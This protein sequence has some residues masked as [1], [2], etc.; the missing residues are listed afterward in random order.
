M[1]TLV[2][3]RHGQSQWNL[4]NRFTGWV[5]VDLSKQGEAEAVAAGQTLRDAGIRPDVVHTSVQKRAIRT[6]ELAL[7]EMGSQPEVRRSWRLN[8]RHYGMLQ[9]LDKKETVQEHGEEQVKVWRRSYATPPP[10]MTDEQWQEQRAESVYADVP[11]ADLPRS[12]S[13]ADVVKRMMPYW[14]NDI[15]A[16]L[17]AGKLVLV[18]AHGNSLRALVK[19][20]QG[21]S[22]DE[23]LE[24]NIPTGVPLVYELDD[25]LRP[26]P[27][28]P[29]EERYLGD[30]EAVRAAAQAVAR[31]TGD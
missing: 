7:Q 23:I 28:K 21:Y 3:L 5:D 4:D 22:E 11:D 17:R 15:A 19:D 12:E 26:D 6:A 31:Q 18:V 30:P 14:E 13:L 10:P 25:D 8:Q 16:D 29:L 27:P 20:L 24:V 1:P 2:L 9:G